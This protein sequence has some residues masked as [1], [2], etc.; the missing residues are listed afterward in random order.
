MEETDLE[1]YII[2]YFHHLLT[3][4]ER[5]AYKHQITTE[6]AENSKSEQF[7]KMLMTK[8]GTEDPD[9]LSLL[10]DG[11]DQFKHRVA[12]R[13]LRDEPEKVF[14]NN[15]PKCGKLARTPKAKQCRFC[16]HDWH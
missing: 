6:K 10:E 11:Y 16:G 13:I 14:I 5:T 3:E 12:E 15:C 9:I 4:Q 1:Q 8:W 2:I 7:R